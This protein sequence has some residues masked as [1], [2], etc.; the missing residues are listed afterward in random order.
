MRK[1]IIGFAVFC[2]VSII[3]SARAENNAVGNDI[4]STEF[5]IDTALAVQMR[6][7]SHNFGPIMQHLADSIAALHGGR[8]TPTN[9]KS[10][11][12]TLRKCN[13]DKVQADKLNDLVRCM[14]AC[15][16]D[17][18]HFMITDLVNTAKKKGLF[19]YY[20]H[21]E[22]VDRG[23][24]GDMVILDHGV[25]GSEIQVKSFYMAYANYEGDIIGFIGDSIFNE[26]KKETGL[27]PCMSHRYYEI[28]RDVTGK[29]SDDEKRK[30][31]EENVKY[32]KA[33][34]E[35]YEEGV[36]FY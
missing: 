6:E 32:L 28:I 9:Y 27:Q 11:S 10:L 31:V 33:F 13:T 18:L 14:I 34:W 26:I 19:K 8:V 30:A 17:S 21:Q 25:I 7:I 3:C 29:Y 20:K 1:S 23:Y 12:S 24:W 4:D 5:R 15:P 16:Y 2:I 36:R 22:Y 35:D